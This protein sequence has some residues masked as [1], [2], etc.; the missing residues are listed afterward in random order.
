MEHFRNEQFININTRNTKKSTKN[1]ILYI[2]TGY[3]IYTLPVFM[4]LKLIL[5]HIYNIDTK[6]CSTNYVLSDQV[7]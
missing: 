5:L 6:A 7:S 2:K 4:G 3:Q 1:V